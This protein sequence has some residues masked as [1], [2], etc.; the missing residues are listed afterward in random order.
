MPSSIPLERSTTAIASVEPER[1]ETWPAGE[2]EPRQARPP[3]VRTSSPAATSSSASASAPAPSTASSA[4]DQRQL[5]GCGPQVADADLGV[6]RIDDRGLVGAP[7]QRLGVVDEIAVERVGAGNEQREALAAAARAAPLLAQARDAAG[8]ADRERAV[9]QPDVDAELERLGRD[10]AEQAARDEV[11]LDAPPLLG[12]VARA[13]RREA[14]G[15]LALARGD[16][17]LA[18]E[19]VHELAGLAALDEADRAQAARGERRE[20][21]G[22]LAQR[23]AARALRLVEQRGVPERHAARR[24]RRAVVV[25]DAHVEPGQGRAGLGGVRDRRAREQELRPLS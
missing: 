1:R 15:H 21:A 19:A 20:Q 3:G 13:V 8:E 12:R 17:A 16:Q 22:G 14:V 18:R 25:H 10:D 23:G 4:G 24:V 6:G 7:E 11:A 2:P 5:A 9:E